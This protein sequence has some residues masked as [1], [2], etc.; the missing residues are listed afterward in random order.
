MKIQIVSDLHIDKNYDHMD[1]MITPIP[2]VRVLILAGDVCSCASVE[3][4]ELFKTF[5]QTYCS[6]YPY[7]LHVAGNHE[8][9]NPKRISGNPVSMFNIRLRLGKLMHEIPNYYYLDNNDM[10]IDGV[11]FIGTTLWCHLPS[12]LWLYYQHRISDYK[13]IYN[14]DTH[15][16]LDTITPEQVC[17]LHRTSTRYIEHI[18]SITDNDSKVVLITH[19]PLIWNPIGRDLS[20]AYNNHLDHMLTPPVNLAVHGHTHIPMD[21]WIGNV[22]V[23][24]NPYGYGSE[25][26][27]SYR[28]DYVVDV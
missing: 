9:H 26:S 20:Y 13:Y 12:H 28:S 24:S 16:N 5:I 3:G 19:H 23:V 8:F 11:H 6:S 2:D 27:T 17:M 15:C 22:H 1:A 14:Y 21:K 7:V 4:L 25:C 18:L 10:N